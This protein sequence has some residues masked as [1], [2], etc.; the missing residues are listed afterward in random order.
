VDIH[1]ALDGCGL[2]KNKFNSK[3]QEPGKLEDFVGW[4]SIYMHDE[5][6]TMKR[7]LELEVES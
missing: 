4:S 3:F 5:V 7:R 6:D 2:Q 1:N